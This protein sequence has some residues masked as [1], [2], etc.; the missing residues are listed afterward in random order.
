MT[1]W[2]EPDL[3]SVFTGSEPETAGPSCF[4]KETFSGTGTQ[5]ICA[6]V[7]FGK[8]GVR[9]RAPVYP[10]LSARIV[11]KTFQNGPVFVFRRFY[12]R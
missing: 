6:P 11:L 4:E 12:R 2:P 7:F 1:V 9:I 10:P 3:A 5:Y 8:S